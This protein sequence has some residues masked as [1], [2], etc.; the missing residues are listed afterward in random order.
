[1]TGK[2]FLVFLG[3]FAAWYAVSRYL[4]PKMGVPT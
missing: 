2:D 4:L 1:M 3:V